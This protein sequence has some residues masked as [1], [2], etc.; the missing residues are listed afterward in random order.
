MKFVGD[1]SLHSHKNWPNGYSKDEMKKVSKRHVHTT[2][3]YN[4]AFSG[5]MAKMSVAPILLH[6]DHITL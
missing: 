3:C 6:P 4:G 1:L 2:A 5:V